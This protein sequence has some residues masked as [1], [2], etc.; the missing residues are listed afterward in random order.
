VT[1]ASNGTPLSFLPLGGV[2][3]IGMNN[4]VMRWEDKRYLID[5]GVMFPDER[6]SFADKVLPDL[7]WI[8]EHASSFAGMVLTHG[9]EDHVGAVAFVLKACRMPVYGSRF[10]LGLIQRRLDEHKLTNVDLRLLE[11]DMGAVSP[12][13]CPELSFELI[14]VTHSIPDAASLVIRT[15]V[16]A[17]LHTGDFKIDDDPMDDED[18]DT[19]AF[20]D[21]G[22]EGV[23]LMMSDSTNAQVPGANI[24]ERDVVHN[25][26]AIVADWPGRVII[27]QFASNLHRLRGMEQ[28]AKSTGRRLCLIGRSLRTYSD[29]ARAAGLA[30]IDA[31]SVLR[32]EAAE[33]VAPEELLVV[34][35]GSQAERRA[36]LMRAALD[37]SPFIKIRKGDLVLMSARNIPGNE[38]GIYTMINELTR[39][40]AKVMHRG[41][42]GIHTSGHAKR[43][44]LTRMIQLVRPRHFVP[45]HGEYAFLTD[46][47][48]LARDAGVDKTLIITNGE[49]FTVSDEDGLRVIGEHTLET[50][51]EDG[52][53]VG[54]PDELR[55]GD[56]RK[57]FHNGLVAAHVQ[58]RKTEP[59]LC[60]V[61]LRSRGVYT[62]KGE[63]LNRAADYVANELAV[64][65]RAA[66]D[67]L[68]EELTSFAVKR[69]F[70]KAVGKK[71]DVVTFVTHVA[72]AAG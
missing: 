2:G 16:G 23:L 3:K 49:E 46:H 57:M 11:P 19:Q 43:D 10:T 12:P 63:L 9:H 32:A 42:P 45:V 70:R 13:E 4:L 15:P 35:T 29:I 72:K 52:S 69:F 51:Y 26:E 48:S 39:R 50:F 30:S 38:A 58:V 6:T 8:E 55:F 62:D 14:R 53:M 20:T 18:F 64:R 56:R 5:A 33:S 28:V 27:C 25:I 68:I 31:T 24:T 47:A 65:R 44:E 59:L 40:G 21:L 54:T 66:D 67:D 22:D 60:D 1:N 41:V 34:I 71:P 37:D 7:K 61:E 17:I 36:G